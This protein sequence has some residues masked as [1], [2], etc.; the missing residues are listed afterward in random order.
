M[1]FI[2]KAAFVFTATNRPVLGCDCGCWTSGIIPG[3][4]MPVS[5]S[6]FVSR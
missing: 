3:L 5:L 2:I 1:G 6:T 4:S